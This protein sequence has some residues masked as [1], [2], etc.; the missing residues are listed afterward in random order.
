MKL[1][2]EASY[3]PPYF[4]ITSRFQQALRKENILLIIIGF[5]FKEKHIQNAILEAVNQN[6]SFQLVIINYSSSNVTIDRQRLKD[7]FDDKECKIIKRNVTIIFD[8]FMDFL[9]ELQS[10]IYLIVREKN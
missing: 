9:L 1:K 7:F 10:C 8:A 5:G 3:E 2:D 4:E 6:P